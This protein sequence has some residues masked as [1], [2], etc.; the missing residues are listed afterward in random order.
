[1]GADP[2]IDLVATGEEALAAGD[3]QGARNAF[4]RRRR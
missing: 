1:M 3:W 2:T 4:R